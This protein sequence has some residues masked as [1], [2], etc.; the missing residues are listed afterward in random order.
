MTIGD[1]LVH[2][3]SQIVSSPTKDYG[4]VRRNIWIIR[5]RHTVIKGN[6]AFKRSSALV[7]YVV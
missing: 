3:I 5:G 2:G 4:D 6:D 1:S 7:N